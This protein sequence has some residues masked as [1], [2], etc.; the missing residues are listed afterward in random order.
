MSQH[1]RSIVRSVILEAPG[2]A[3]KKGKG[4]PKKE[5]EKKEEEENN[6]YP[7][8]VTD[9][10]KSRKRTRRFF[11]DVFHIADKY[12]KYPGVVAAQA[13]HESGWGTS[14]AARTKNNFLGLDK[15]V[16]RNPDVYERRT[17]KTPD[18]CVKF[19]IRNIEAQLSETDQGRWVREIIEEIQRNNYSADKAYIKKV[20][21]AIA[22][23]TVVFDSEAAYGIAERDYLARYAP[24]L[25]ELGYRTA[26]VAHPGN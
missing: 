9:L 19:Y 26:F 24:E 5:E 21:D 14:L 4:K 6:G 16:S 20:T 17:F 22:G 11:H 7:P 1:L 12:S 18:D 25:K 8:Y 2:A 10:E 15:L 3:A 23:P 13:A